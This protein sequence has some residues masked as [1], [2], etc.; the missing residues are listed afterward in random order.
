MRLPGLP[1][2]FA[3]CV[4]GEPAILLVKRRAAEEVPG[5]EAIPQESA[6]ADHQANGEIEVTVREIKKQVRVLKMDLESKLGVKVEDKH[7]VLA[8]LPEHA[9]SV[10]N[11]YRR[12][13][14]GKTAVQRLTGRQWRNPSRSLESG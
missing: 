12:G 4:R 9:A 3:D 6:P 13:P 7:P 11:R 5:L 14:D 2:S 10:I 1:M 8:H